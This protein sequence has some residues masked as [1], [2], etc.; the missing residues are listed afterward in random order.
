MRD[1]I[2]FTA[3]VVYHGG[4][5]PTVGVY[6]IE[7]SKPGAVADGWNTDI[8]LANEPHRRE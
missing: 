6:G 7:G 1:L 2:A 5:N 8:A 3:S 4:V